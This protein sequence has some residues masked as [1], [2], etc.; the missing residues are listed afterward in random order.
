MYSPADTAAYTKRERDFKAVGRIALLETVNKTKPKAVR[1]FATRT[2]D[3]QQRFGFAKHIAKQLLCRVIFLA[4]QLWARRGFRRRSFRSQSRFYAGFLA[5]ASLQPSSG[6]VE[7]PLSRSATPPRR[8][9]GRAPW[10]RLR[11]PK[12]HRLALLSSGPL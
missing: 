6:G 12:S 8:A 10:A 9:R 5:F 3:R 4:S 7:Q 1:I 11:N 2:L